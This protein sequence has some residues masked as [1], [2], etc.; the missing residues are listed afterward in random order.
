MVECKKLNMNRLSLSCLS[1]MPCS[2]Y[3]DM[4]TAIA[5]NL[6][7]YTWDSFILRADD[8]TV[9]SPDGP[10][11]NSVRLMSN[12]TYETHVAMYVC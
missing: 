6:T 12:K 11:R 7:S 9:L 3:T 1:G 8:K 2:N 5:N 10:G 4:Q